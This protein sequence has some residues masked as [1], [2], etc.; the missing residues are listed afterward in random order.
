MSGTLANF[1]VSPYKMD[2]NDWYT[3]Q[4]KRRATDEF[5]ERKKEKDEMGMQEMIGPKAQINFYMDQAG[6]NDENTKYQ[7]HHLAKYKIQVD[8]M[9]KDPLCSRGPGSISGPCDLLSPAYQFAHHYFD[10]IDENHE[11][12]KGHK[13]FISFFIGEVGLK[14]R[15]IETITDILK[16]IV[17]D[18][19]KKR[20]PLAVALKFEL[21]RQQAYGMDK[22]AH[23]NTSVGKISTCR[24]MGRA[25]TSQKRR[26]Q[27]EG[28]YEL[29]VDP[30]SAWSLNGPQNY[31]KRQEIN[32][33]VKPLIDK[34]IKNHNYK[35]PK[36]LEE[37]EENEGKV[38]IVNTS[39]LEVLGETGGGRRRRSRKRK[40]RKSRKSR[41]RIKTRRKSRR[42]SR[43]R[44]RRTKRK[45]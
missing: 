37:E 38:Y 22:R 33:Q 40:S 16:Q 7:G 36:E 42:K 45:R 28:H 17:E 32:E 30:N 3:E 35:T 6:L 26:K 23:I 15:K 14:K 29:N 21:M 9:K 44:K 2:S 5:K 41:K 20:A 31:D 27:W 10:K 8:S 11:V 24:R 4:D 19:N 34:H 1:D 18:N 13:D 12:K 43:R 25:C 39:T